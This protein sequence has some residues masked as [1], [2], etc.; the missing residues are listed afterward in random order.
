VFKVHINDGSALPDDDV[1][2]IVAK[3]GIFLK[4]KLGVMESIAP[5]K[6]ISILNTVQTMARMHIAKIPARDFASVMSF[7]REVYGIHH[8][9]AVVLLFYK[10]ERKKHKVIAP[11]QKVSGAG[12]DYARGMTMEGMHMIGTIHS[13]ADF[14]A[15]HSGTDSDDEKAFDGLH[16]TIGHNGS[17]T[18]SITASIVSNGHRFIVDPLDYVE[19]L[20]LVS[21][22]NESK[23]EYHTKIYKYVAGKLELDEEASKK[24]AVTFNRMDKR[25]IIDLPPEQIKHN[26][27]WIKMVEKNTYQWQGGKH[28]KNGR[29]TQGWGPNYA[30]GWWDDYYGA[31]YGYTPGGAPS[32]PGVSRSIIVRGGEPGTNGTSGVTGLPQPLFDSE[33]PC[34]TCKHRDMKILIEEEDMA[35]D[36]FECFKCRTIVRESIEVGV[37]TICPVCKTDEFLFEVDAD[38]LKDRY[39]K[40]DTPT[41]I[42]PIEAEGEFHK[43]SACR[44]TFNKVK[45]DVSC[46]FCYEAI[47]SQEELFQAQ[48]ETDAGAQLSLLNEKDVEI[49]ES[50]AVEKIPDPDLDS[51]PL[52]TRVQATSRMSIKEMMRKVFAKKGP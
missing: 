46:P 14:S 27:N 8:S 41:I 20:K 34:F 32:P 22:I 40:S 38:S 31:T 1:Y 18:Q 33:A 42:T 47:Y 51:M 50:H 39:V 13:H 35:P 10:Q 48:L 24:H 12:A 44:N 28:W 43:C 19:G 23:T 52:S 3:E 15:F 5:V 6:N 49:V 16:I 21:D 4:K 7:F 36:F 11:Q 30:A 2:Y 37:D 45:K 29:T 25:Y 17:P 9:E 26:P